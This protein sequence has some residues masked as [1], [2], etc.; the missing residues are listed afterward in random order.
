MLHKNNDKLKH[1][2]PRR[3]TNVETEQCKN[4]IAMLINMY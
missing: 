1:Q 3:H 4:S 2:G